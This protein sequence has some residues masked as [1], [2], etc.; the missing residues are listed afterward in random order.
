ML[1][2]VRFSLLNLQSIPHGRMVDCLWMPEGFPFV[3]G[4]MNS[5]GTVP[6]KNSC[7]LIFFRL[8]HF[9]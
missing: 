3:P 8:Y 1:R 5:A 4:R 6:L 7:G 9:S 2:G